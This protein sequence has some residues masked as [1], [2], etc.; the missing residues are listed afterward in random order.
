LIASL[1][2]LSFVTSFFVVLFTMCFQHVLSVLFN[3]DDY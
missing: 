1:C 2:V 3:G